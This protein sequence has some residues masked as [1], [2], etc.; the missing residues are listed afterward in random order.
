G[1]DA[2][3]LHGSET[4]WFCAEFKGRVKVIKAFGID[5]GFDFDQL[6]PYKNLV[7]Y[8][9]F[10]TKTPVHGGS[11]KTF[12]WDML[13]AYTLNLPFFLSGGISIDH[14]DV[15]K[16]IDHPQL[17]GVD[18]NSRFE[19]SPGI[20]NIELLTAAFKNTKQI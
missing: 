13:N 2:I 3:Q 7:D 1:F 20:K 6:I 8:F 17:Y 9:L 15:I 12:N 11:G 5:N 18:L 16:K 14:L 19:I 10:D 4:P